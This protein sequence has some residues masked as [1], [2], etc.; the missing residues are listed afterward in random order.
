[1]FQGVFYLSPHGSSQNGMAM[2]IVAN[3]NF[4]YGWVKMFAIR[5]DFLLE[6]ELAL[7]SWARIT[8]GGDSLRLPY[9]DTR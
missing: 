9:P 1:M 7:N 8:S 5:M 4:L 6:V 2:I 3:Y